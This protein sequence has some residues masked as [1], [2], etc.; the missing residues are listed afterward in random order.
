MTNKNDTSSIKAV[1]TLV[2]LSTLSLTTTINTSGMTYGG[3]PVAIMDRGLPNNNFGTT[4]PSPIIRNVS[5]QTLY[6]LARELFDGEM[7]D[8]TQE[9]G[10]IYKASLKKIYKPIGVNIFD[11]C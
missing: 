4:T 2:A 3:L 5:K 6:G 7:R 10:E 11:L 8:F 1:V 9:E